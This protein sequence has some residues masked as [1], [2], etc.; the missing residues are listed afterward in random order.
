V[1]RSIHTAKK[2][3]KMTRAQHARKS[4]STPPQEDDDGYLSP[5]EIRE[6]KQR[7]REMDD[8]VRYMLVSEF[9]RRFILYYNVSDDVFAMN[10]PS[11]GTLFKR[12]EAAQRVRQVLGK[13]ISIIKYTTGGGTLRRLSSLRLYQ[14]KK[15]RLRGM[16]AVRKMQ[17]HS[18]EAGIDRLSLDNINAEIRASRKR[19]RR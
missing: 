6:I 15:R 13:G 12:R 5:A 10:N 2:P 19:Q 3:N 8:P 18:V 14:S 11:G 17:R 7:V 4:F 9:S 1:R 16:A